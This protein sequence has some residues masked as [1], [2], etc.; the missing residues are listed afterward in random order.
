MNETQVTN[1]NFFLQGKSSGDVVGTDK[2]LQDNND[3]NWF[4]KPVFK[5][6]REIKK[7]NFKQPGQKQVYRVKPLNTTGEKTT[8]AT[9][10]GGILKNISVPSKSVWKKFKEFN[11]QTDGN[12]V[13]SMSNFSNLE[14]KKTKTKIKSVKSK[15][16]KV[17]FSNDSEPEIT[18]SNFHES[19]E[20]DDK[21]D[22]KTSDSFGVDNGKSSDDYQ[23]DDYFSKSKFV[24]GGKK[25]YSN[26]HVSRNL[27]K[28][29]DDNYSKVKEH[30][31]GKVTSLFF[32]NPE[33]P[34]IPHRAVK[35]IRED[36]FSNLKF[37]DLNL[38]SYM[39]N[40]FFFYDMYVVLFLFFF[41]ECW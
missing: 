1:N 19:V 13:K 3:F 12:D 41:C 9:Q 37:E 8:G 11:K 30:K 22:G 17:S 20:N 14:N 35:P 18:K 24:K 27:N 28:S 34:N 6:T 21:F 10:G 39:V 25:N 16:K 36:V 15:F 26:N 31:M 7:T 38:H 40:C 32:N 33:I 5:N 4:D 29:L 23:F 2:I